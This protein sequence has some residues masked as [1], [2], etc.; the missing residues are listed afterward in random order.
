MEFY[1]QTTATVNLRKLM[2]GKYLVMYKIKIALSVI[3]GSLLEKIV[4]DTTAKLYDDKSGKNKKLVL[5]SAHEYNLAA[6]LH[7][8]DVFI[9]E[10]P[11]YASY[12]AFEV[13][14]VSNVYTVKVRSRALIVSFPPHLGFSRFYTKT[15]AKQNQFN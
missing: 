9:P 15:I 3:L 8:L 11:P 14:N 5:Y 10:V 4:M 13:H 1:R 2:C 12:I 6:M 7:T